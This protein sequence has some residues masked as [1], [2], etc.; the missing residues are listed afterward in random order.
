MTT[1]L[2]VSTEQE[3]NQAIATVDAATTGSFVINLT[4]NITE[5][6]DTG[7]HIDYAGRMLSAPPDL[8]ALNTQAGVQVTID[9][10]G[11]TLDG[12]GTYRGLFVYDGTIGI[13]DL[14]LQDDKAAGGRGGAG[15][16]AGGG[17]AGLGG[18]LFVAAGGD[19]RLDGV[20]FAAD[21]A[22]G[23]NGGGT[24]SGGAG[25]GG[26]LGGTGGT[27]VGG[28]G[29]IGALALGG[30]VVGGS[31]YNVGAP[32][33]VLGAAGG[34][35]GSENS[36]KIA[37]GSAGG[38]G[39]AG[40]GG[41][42]GG[43]GGGNAAPYSGNGAAGGFGGGGGEGVVGG[44]G[45]FGGGGGGA[46]RTGGAGGFGGGGGGVFYVEGGG[47]AGGFG[48]GAGST[49][50]YGGGGLGAG[51]DVFVQQ[52]GVLVVQG[53]SLAAGTVTAGAGS[54]GDPA[55]GPG[56]AFGNGLFI[57][58]DQS[59]TLGAAASQTLTV[60]G[61]IADQTGSGGTGTNA[62]AGHLVIDG[63]GTVA[64]RADNTYT[65]GTTLDPRAFLELG[66]VH[67][68]GSGAV[69][70]GAGAG[71]TLALNQ[72]ITLANTLEAFG[73][74]DGILLYDTTAT[75][76]VVGGGALDVTIGGRTVRLAGYVSGADSLMATQ[77]GANTLLTLSCFAEG[78]RIAV[79][80]GAVPVEAL[81]VGDR[82][83]VAG[84][85]TR[86]VVWIGSRRVDVRRHP[87]PR[88]VRPVEIAAGAFGS[89]RPSRPLRLSPDH[90]VWVEGA[91]IPVRYLVDGRLIRRMRVT[92][93]TYWH[94]ELDGHD[95]LLA[96]GLA[97]ESFLGDRAVFAGD[98]VPLHP[99]FHARRREAEAFAPLVV[100]GPAVERAR[101][102]L[103]A[104][105]ATTASP[106]SAA[107]A[108]RE[109]P[110]RSVR[111]AR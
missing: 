59:V 8:F 105:A 81:R 98:V 37:G 89:G 42:G 100:T 52:G 28:G 69:V 22:V 32:G 66:T 63:P 10:N 14:V 108:P 78:T 74:G 38:G 41:G 93:V 2:T 51:G 82:V 103:R 65:G 29:G 26:G 33:I 61:V 77:L 30:S 21:A 54:P 36:N 75:D 50:G 1:T 55:G 58:G 16:F 57:Q 101:A 60:G 20:S 62:G 44:H 12:A 92:A 13:N 68:A 11:H 3:L 34:G 111:A 107:A 24:R 56:S 94:V 43:V 31:T 110:A 80:R 49:S 87:R 91:L 79:A 5:G 76:P 86:P 84:G 35:T 40:Y 47:G 67:A 25:G 104:R 83:R 39:G 72:G 95:R 6:T 9:G 45:G 109:R 106:A 90:A 71:A 96:E 70:F 7:A 23:G 88:D 99:D 15:N 18:G 17:G 53:G 85:E 102:R 64:L 46:Y 48:G 27:Y 4:A 19:V 97:S 73:Q